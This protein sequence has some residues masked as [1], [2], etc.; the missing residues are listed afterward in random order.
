[1]HWGYYDGYF[2]VEVNQIPSVCVEN[3]VNLS[4]FITCWLQYIDLLT[5]DIWFRTM[6]VAVICNFHDQTFAT[7]IEP[8]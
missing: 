7:I 1:M 3:N 4:L 2:S 5:L 8:K 6:F